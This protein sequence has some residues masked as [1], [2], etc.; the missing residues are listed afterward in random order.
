MVNVQ[1][2]LL[3]ACAEGNLK[4]MDQLYQ[5][6]HD[7]R[8]DVPPELMLKEAVAHGQAKA[9]QYCLKLGAKI[10]YDVVSICINKHD[11]TTY[12]LLVLAGLDAN[13][14]FHSGDALCYAAQED[15]L[16]FATFLLSRGADPNAHLMA[17]THSPLALAAWLASVDLAALLLAHGAQLNGSGALVVAA[18]NGRLDMVRFLLQQ[19]ADVNEFGVEDHADARTRE[20]MATSL[21]HAATEGYLEVVKLLLDHGARTDLRD[22]QGRTVLERAEQENYP[23]IVKLLRT[24]GA[25]E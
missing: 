3:A 20:D 5:K 23:G 1:D 6:A 17:D 16:S 21:Q 22:F 11:W 19:G 25:A 14:E 10:E 18:Q 24:H 15:N 9:V 4:K 7:S 2:E 13:Y 8:V 12:E